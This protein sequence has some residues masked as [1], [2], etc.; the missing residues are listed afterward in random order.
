M[1]GLEVLAEPLITQLQSAEVADPTERPLDDIAG[2][3]QPAA[4]LLPRLAIR[5]QQRLDPPLHHFRDDR[6][7][8]VGTVTLERPRPTPRPAAP[9]DAGRDGVEHLQGQLR[10]GLIGRAGADHQRDPGGVGHDVALAAVLPAIRGVRAG[11]RPPFSA[12]T[13]ALSMTA[14]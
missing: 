2:L 8:P 7:D 12:L 11:V 13:E 5:R 4:V 6:L 14:R 1:K 10:I 9:A 3:A